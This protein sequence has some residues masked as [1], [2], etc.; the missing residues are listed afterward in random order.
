MA[1]PDNYDAGESFAAGDDIVALV[2]NGAVIR[3]YQRLEDL[4]PDRPQRLRVF[5]AILEL[6][7]GMDAG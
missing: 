3:L 4:I 7:Y 5:R 1:V 6:A 2:E